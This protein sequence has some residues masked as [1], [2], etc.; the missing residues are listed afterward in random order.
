MLDA[1]FER[2]DLF[3]LIMAR[4]TGFIFFNPLFGRRNIPGMGRVGMALFF[5]VFTIM[6]FPGDYTTVDISNM[7]VFMFLLT[8]EFAIGYL[9]GLIVNMFLSVVT[10]AG[11]VMDM[12]MGLAMSQMYDPGSNV[13]MPI[14][15][16]FYNVALILMFFLTNS[17]GTLIRILILSFRISPV[18]SFYLNPDIGV[19]IARLFGSI[20][21]LCL[22]L[23]FPVIAAELITE[24]GVGIIMRA[25]PQINVFVVGLQLKIFAGIGIMIVCAPV[26]VWFFDGMLHQMSES[27]IEAVFILAGR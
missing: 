27:A 3:L 4:M 17:H 24:A 16:S 25:V 20:L 2:Y 8:K 19:Y 22:K 7:I 23:A 9:L 26:S 11:E 12:Q 13:N 21:V 1:V 5:S 15:G 14:T 10:I 6:Y 18:D